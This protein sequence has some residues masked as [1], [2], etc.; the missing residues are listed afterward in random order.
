L[1]FLAV[2]GIDESPDGVFRGPLSYSPDL[3]KFVKMAQMLVVQ[4]SVVAVEEGEVEYPSYMLD[5][6]R[7]RFM[8]RGSWTAFDWACRLRSYAKKVVSNI[9]SLGHIAWLE[10]GS[11]VTYKDIGF[12]MDVLRN[13]IAV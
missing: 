7:D 13:F 2:I 9:T 12:S 5:E 6:M 3:S 4:R 10:D 11:L 1:S 8:V